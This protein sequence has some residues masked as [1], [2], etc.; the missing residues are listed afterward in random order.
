MSLCVVYFFI[1]KFW[2]I[3]NKCIFRVVSISVL[4]NFQWKKNIMNFRVCSFYFCLIC[5]KQNGWN[6]KYRCVHRNFL[7]FLCLY[8]YLYNFQNYFTKYFYLKI[9]L[10]LKKNIVNSKVTNLRWWAIRLNKF[11]F[12]DDHLDTRNEKFHKFGNR[13]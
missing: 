9:W 4:I 10:W 3:E 5:T 6:E 7:Q 13:I 12:P 1:W 8:I 11:L 2:I